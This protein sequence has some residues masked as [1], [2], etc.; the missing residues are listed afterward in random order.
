MLRAPRYHAACR[1]WVLKYIEEEVPYLDWY[2]AEALY[3]LIEDQAY[4]T[5]AEIRVLGC[6]DRYFLLSRLLNRKDA[7]HPWL[8][9]RCR[10]V[11]ASPDGHLDLWARYHYK[12][13][14]ITFAGSI[15]EILCDPEITIA[16]FAVT[17]NIAS[18]FLEQIKDELERNEVLMELYQ[19]VL[20]ERPAREAPSWSVK[21][22]I[23]VKRKGNPKEKTVE[24]FGLIDG[25]PTGRHFV[26]LVYDDLINEKLVTNPDMIKKATE[27]W[28]MSDN[29]GSGERT[30]KWHVG[31]R[32][33]FADTY[34]VLI[35]RG[36]LKP[37]LYPATDNGRLDGTPVFL[38]PEHWEAVKR[39]QVSTVNAQM[40]QNPL[41]GTEQ[42]FKPTWFRPYVLR[43]ATM[44]VYIMVD[45]S[46]GRSAKSDRT[47]M[48]VIG[49]D[50]RMNKYLLDGFRH[51]MN[52]S[53]RYRN[54]VMLWRKWSEAPGV[55]FCKVGYEVYGMQTDD[56]FVR[57]EMI[58]KHGNVLFQ[59]HEL[60]WARD[61]ATQS[62]TH[63]VER[64]EP[65]F[66]LNQF[67]L[68]PMIHHELHGEAYWRIEDN[69]DT[70]DKSQ[71]LL[72]FTKRTGPN[73]FESAAIARGQAHLVASAIKRKDENG[74]IYDVTRELIQEAMFFPFAPKDDL[75]DVVSRIYD[76]E[77]TA[78]QL[79]DSRDLMPPAHEDA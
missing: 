72:H 77:I 5:N 29:L 79:V 16:I 1:D 57:T 76:M 13:T 48:A 42:M 8:F 67:F 75:I 55:Q 47:A 62:K 33:S 30:R 22:G 21:G 73:R 10:E 31:T 64:L 3:D 44:N 59:L 65:D 34:G 40:L 4:F 38:T 39:N 63:R 23:T 68:P 70:A 9:D 6:N 78:P 43:P 54:L 41:S 46:K 11:E 56:E 32:Y 51:R 26:L 53:E 71:Q 52:L 37:R 74:V 14:V 15:Q 2:E 28:E 24:A 17:Q 49:V 7:R 50:A 66:R 27:R 12:S 61:S 69:H 25:M 20:W 18:P 58:R 60:N 45:P 19:D 36:V 35:E